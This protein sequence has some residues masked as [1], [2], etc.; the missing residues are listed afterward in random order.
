MEGHSQVCDPMRIVVINGFVFLGD[1]TFTSM[2]QE[3]SLLFQEMQIYFSFA[4]FKTP[5]KIGFYFK[6]LLCITSVLDWVPEKQTPGRKFAF[7]ETDW[8]GYIV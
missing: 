4:V 2:E 8:E 5:K 6:M 1:R 3:T 7:W